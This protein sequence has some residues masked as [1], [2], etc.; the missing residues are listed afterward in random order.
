MYDIHMHEVS[1][2]FAECWQAAGAHLDSQVQGGIQG[3]LKASLRPPYLEHM[4]FRLGNQLFFIRLEDVEGKLETP[5]NPD[6][7]LRKAEGCKGH[8]CVMPMR[9]QSGNWSPDYPRWGLV[10][11]LT[12]TLVDPVALVSDELME[13]PDWELYDF[14]VQIVRDHLDEKGYELMSWSGDPEIEPALWFVGES[15]PEWVVVRVVRYPELEAS[16][17]GNWSEIAEQCSRTSDVGHF[18]S[19]SVANGDDASDPSDDVPAMPLWRGHGMEVRFEG[20]TPGVV[21]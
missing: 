5:G 19:V 8:P 11:A 6:G 4:S 2:E 3:W 20:L 9:N 12:G 21:Q 1:D 7:L 16:P 15:G 18:A 10:N 14:A 17:P 13:M